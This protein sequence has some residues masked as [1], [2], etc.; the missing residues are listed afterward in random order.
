MLLRMRLIF[1]ICFFLSACSTLPESPLLNRSPNALT[2]RVDAL[3]PAD[4]LIL[5]E[6]H[7][8][9]EHQ[10][11]AQQVIEY[12]AVRG[13]LGA[14]VIE[15]AD[16]NRDTSELTSKAEQEDISFALRW[17]DRTWPWRAYGPVVITAV[18][19]GA[20]VSGGNLLAARIR[21]LHVDA[22]IEKKLSPAALRT[23]QQL[24]RSSHCDLIPES[25][26][27]SM[28]RIQIARDMSMAQMIEKTRVPGKVTVLLTGS[29]H[30]DR[31]M[32]VPLHLP[33]QLRVKSVHL[34]A[35]EHAEYEQE[36]FDLIWPTSQ[37]ETVDYCP[38]IQKRF[39][40]KLAAVSEIK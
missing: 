31:L 22:E 23:Q 16:A 25:Q 18:R 33:P 38:Q 5:G 9:P 4:V 34:K 21:N 19:S 13:L 24:I 7:N 40:E 27:P 30:A 15:M 37:L 28:S 29:V 3:L 11:I 39:Q 20:V 36:S 14:V 17:K 8:A 1:L 2:A 12:L 6:Q 35:G 26:I 10:A 32:G